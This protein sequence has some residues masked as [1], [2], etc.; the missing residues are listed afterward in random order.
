MWRRPHLCSV[1]SVTGLLAV[2]G[3]HDTNRN[4]PLDPELTPAVELHAT[5]LD[6]RDGAAALT[7]SM[8][9]GDQPFQAYEIQRRISG[10]A[11]TVPLGAIAEVTE[12]AFVDTSIEADRTYVYRVSVVNSSGWRVASNASEVR[13]SLQPPLL[14]PG[15]FDSQS[16][17]ALLSW[18]RSASGFERYEVHRQTERDAGTL[19]VDRTQDIQDTTLAD[20]GLEGDTEYTYTVVLRSTTGKELRSSP[21]TGSFHAYLRE[22]SVPGQMGGGL[23]ID[24]D[25]RVYAT[26][27]DPCLIYQFTREGDLV[28][29]FPTDPTWDDLPASYLA[30]SADGVYGLISTGLAG[31]HVN[32]FSPDG[33]PLFR[34][35]SQRANEDLAGVAVSPNGE[36]WIAGTTWG[37]DERQ[38]TLYSVAPRTGQLLDTLAVETDVYGA[39]LA[40]QG[41]VGVCFGY[42]SWGVVAFDMSTGE[43]LHTISGPGNVK[44]GLADPVASA[45]GPAGRLFIVD[46]GSLRIHVFR[47]AEYVTGWGRQGDAPGSFSLSSPAYGTPPSGIAI[48]SRG[49]IYVADTG[50]NRVQVFAP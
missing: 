35:A 39:G 21:Q 23:A 30:A 34:W 42:K 9:E 50:N 3:C 37:S 46:A 33:S 45:F 16:A 36:L 4:N 31:G 12:T 40:I 28:R 38:T 17:S 48:D 20:S 15:V 5:V 32:G 25:D 10:E 29:E 41:A 2:A 26:S 6:G 22:W 47:G 1:C 44:G 49:E 18:S 19:I 11:A 8:Y 14:Q 7:W 24:P 13:F 27:A 43:T